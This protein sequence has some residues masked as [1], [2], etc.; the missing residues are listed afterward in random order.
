MNSNLN[1][2]S[3]VLSEN[4]NDNVNNI[5][6]TIKD[7]K[8]YVPVVTL[9]VRGNWKLPKLLSKGLVKYQFL[10]MNR[11]QKVDL[12]IFLNQILLESIDYLFYSLFKPR[13]CF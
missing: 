13:C 9:S 1:E 6:F 8:L 7:T 12:D 2:Q 4:G 5:I 10:G 11:K 3:I